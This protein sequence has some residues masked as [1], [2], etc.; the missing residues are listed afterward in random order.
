MR[1][2]FPAVDA[3]HTL[4]IDSVGRGIPCSPGPHGG[5]GLVPLALAHL[6]DV[7]T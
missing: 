6:V 7:L 4:C 3:V 1:A 5:W 2:P